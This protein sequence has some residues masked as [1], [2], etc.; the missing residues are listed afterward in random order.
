MKTKTIVLAGVLAFCAVVLQPLHGADQ[1]SKASSQVGLLD[2]RNQL[3]ALQDDVSSVVGSLN[4]V[5]GSA[6]KQDE[7]AKAHADLVSRFDTL[8]NR[9]ETLRSN[10]VTL[11]ATVNTHYEA[12]AKELTAMQNASLREKAQD[13]LTRSQK[14]FEK[15]SA[16]ANDAKEQLLP[17]VSEVKD[18]VIYLNADLSEQAVDSLSST[19]WKLGNKSKSVIGRIGDVIEQINDTVKSLPKK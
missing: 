1:P 19:I 7:L 11:K 8:Q 2:L 6:K 14:E 10:A 5:K 15:I 3:M 4:A 16:E 13:R 12:W 17:F 9:V 18:C